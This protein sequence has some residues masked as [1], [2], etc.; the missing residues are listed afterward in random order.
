MVFV[1]NRELSK[2]EV[3]K[4]NNTYILDMPIRM[5]PKPYVEDLKPFHQRQVPAVKKDSVKLLKL[6]QKVQSIRSLRACTKIDYRTV[7]GF[8]RKSKTI[9]HLSSSVY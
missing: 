7:A 5:I 8:R 6:D 1:K 4:F 2:G 9:I 3:N